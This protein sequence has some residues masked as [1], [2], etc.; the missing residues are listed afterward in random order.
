MRIVIV[1]NDLRDAIY[2]RVDQAIARSPG[3]YVDRDTFYQTLLNYY[4]EHGYIPE[5][6]LERKVETCR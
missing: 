1:P 4:D 3:A 6:T 5:F 2:D